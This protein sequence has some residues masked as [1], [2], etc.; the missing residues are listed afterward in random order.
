[1]ADRRAEVE[2]PPSPV[3]ALAG[4]AYGELAGERPQ[5][6]AQGDELLTGGVHH[7][8]VLGQGLAHRLGQGLAPPVGHQTAPD[9]VLDL[10]SQL[11][12]PGLE[13]VAQ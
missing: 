6:L 3:P 2:G 8:D 13:L 5:C 12:D 4:Q 10:P 7:V 1:M 11:V 9:L